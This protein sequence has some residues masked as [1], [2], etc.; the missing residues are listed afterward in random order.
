MRFNDKNKK[1]D[2]EKNMRKVIK[3]YIGNDEQRIPV[4]HFCNKKSMKNIFF[5]E[6]FNF[7][8]NLFIFY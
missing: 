2:Q 7:A 6:N 5:N 4:D 3:R 8:N 1:I